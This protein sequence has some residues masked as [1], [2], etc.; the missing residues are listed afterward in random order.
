MFLIPPW[1]DQTMTH[2]L[3]YPVLLAKAIGATTLFV[4][5]A[6]WAVWAFMVIPIALVLT[7]WVRA[8]FQAWRK[9]SQFRRNR[10]PG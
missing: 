6:D 2:S 3:P 1:I 9:R 8:H 7:A 10:S 4:A 5:Y